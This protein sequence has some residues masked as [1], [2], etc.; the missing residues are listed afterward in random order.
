MAGPTDI[1]DGA[2]GHGRMVGTV[3]GMAVSALSGE[4]VLELG[5]FMPFEGRFMAGPADVPLHPLEKP[6]IIAGVRG[7]AGCASVFAETNQVIV[8]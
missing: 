8:G 2:F 6:I 4:L 3:R 5:S 1:I 7:M